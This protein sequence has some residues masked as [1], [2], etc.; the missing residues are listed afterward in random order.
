M[1][2]SLLFQADRALFLA[3]NNRL[4]SPMGDGLMTLATIAGDVTVWAVFGSMAIILWDTENA[5][6]RMAAYAMAL[7]ATGLLLIAVKEVVDRDRPFEYFKAGIDAGE[8]QINAP[9][10]MLVARSFPSGHTQAAFTAAT[11]FILY[12]RRH[13]GALLVAALLVG[14]SR[15]YLGAHFPAD[16]VFGAL[17]GA[18][19]AWATWHGEQIFFLEKESASEK[20]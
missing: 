17:L 5:K 3:I 15:I 10:Q 1:N 20:R 19:G 2:E 11:F 6:R 12:Y 8:I 13:C 9:H 7:I 16:V 18:V 14:F 4:A